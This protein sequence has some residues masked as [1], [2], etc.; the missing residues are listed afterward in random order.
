MEGE[1]LQITEEH[2][3]A[4][5]LA[6]PPHDFGDW[7]LVKMV[8]SVQSDGTEILKAKFLRTLTQSEIE[9]LTNK[10]WFYGLK[11]KEPWALVKGCPKAEVTAPSVQANQPRPEKDLNP[12]AGVS[13]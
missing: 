10:F 4:W 3:V 11:I 9:R 5:P 8:A 7:S 1:Y 12:M 2:Y 6:T 13:V